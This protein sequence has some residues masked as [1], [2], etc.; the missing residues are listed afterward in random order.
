MSSAAERGL[1]K[2]QNMCKHFCLGVSKRV[3]VNLPSFARISMRHLNIHL[4]NVSRILLSPPP[5]SRKVAISP[6]LFLEKEKE[7]TIYF[8]FFFA[9]LFLSLLAGIVGVCNPQPLRR[10]EG[11]QAATSK[12]RNFILSLLG[13][14][15]VERG[16]EKR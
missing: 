4:A 14:L 8:R 3:L 2:W 5:N 15:D 6:H 1:L 13:N 12:P 7:R 9:R 16:G 10:K 11:H